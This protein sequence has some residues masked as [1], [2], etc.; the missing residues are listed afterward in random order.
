YS[1]LW[2]QGAAW[3]DARRYGLLSTIPIPPGFSNS[4]P[5]D[6]TFGASNVPDRLLVPDDECR[7]RGL[8]SGCSPL[9]T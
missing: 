7:A 5:P 6:P 2:E 4:T 3:V 1:L 8:E 9:G